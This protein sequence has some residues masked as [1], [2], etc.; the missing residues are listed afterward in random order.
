MLLALSRKLEQK[1]IEENPNKMLSIFESNEIVFSIQH[2]ALRVILSKVLS[3]FR[4]FIYEI[5]DDVICCRNN[6]FSTLLADDVLQTHLQLTGN[7]SLNWNCQKV[8]V[9]RKG[10]C[11]I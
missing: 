4:Y 10:L 5:N 11:D 2:T 9:V 6:K 7:I 8:N 1:I 3:K